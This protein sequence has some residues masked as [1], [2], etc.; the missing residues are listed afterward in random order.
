MSTGV[1]SDDQLQFIRTKKYSRP[2]IKIVS[3][4]DPHSGEGGPSYNII[5]LY[6]LLGANHSRSI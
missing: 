4:V 5:A 6:D 3:K 2:E 1:D